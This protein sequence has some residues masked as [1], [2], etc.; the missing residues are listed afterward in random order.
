MDQLRTELGRVTTSSSRIVLGLGFLS[1]SSI[2]YLTWTIVYNLYF[3]PLAKFPGPKINAISDLPGV[4]WVLRGRLPMETRKLH[5]KYGSVVRL[6]PNELA[7]NTVEAWNDI[8]GHRNGRQDL[9]KDPIH[10]GAVD[11][12]PGVQTISMA[13]HANHARQRKALS[14]G[15]S[16]KAL[17]EQEDI[18][19]G[20][21]DKLM[22]NF[23]GFAERKEVF[24]IVKWYNFITFDVIGDLSFGESFGCLDR[25]D[26]H[27]WISVIFD[28]V[29]AG[30]IEQAT[31]RFATAGST[32]QILMTRLIPSALRKQRADHLAY[33]REKV[34]RRLN[35]TKNQRKDFIYYI[36]KQAEVYDLSQDEVIVNA[37][38][39]IVAGSETTASSL[40]SLTNNLLRYPE[41]YAKLKAEIREAFSSEKEIKLARVNE[42]P[43]L[44]ACIEEGLRIFPPAPIGF[45]RSIQPGGDVI[46]GQHI[47]GGTAVSVS[48]WCAHHCPDNFVEPDSFIPERWLGSEKFAD[49]KKLAFRPFSLGPRGCIGKDLSYLEMR[50]VL[51]R[52]I[53]NFD[54]V[55]ADSAVEWDAEG[56]MKHMKAFSTWQKPHLNVVA[57]KVKR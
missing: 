23:H 54:L 1:I 19:Q 30:A 29:K 56:D 34:M 37:A 2:L 3:H 52:T 43:Y 35:D 33:S 57:T 5:E 45:L 26:F 50:L 27:F 17:W 20:F 46:D 10:V 53:W 12:L 24:D 42:L 8:Y 28:A 15:F 4:I 48:S 25:G 14:H 38:L 7:F 32:T 9:N 55:N 51:A 16:K 21:V 40:A 18:V 6:S 13:D 31:R 49:E 22:K 36:L 11:P 47:P 44:S 39:F 41:V